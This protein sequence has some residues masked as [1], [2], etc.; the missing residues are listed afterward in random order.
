MLGWLAGL[1]AGAAHALSGPDHLAAVAPLA[2]D[3]PRG[4]WRLGLRWGAGHSC[5]VAA[6]GALALAARGSID[7]AGLSGY[8]ERLAG[9]ALVGV[10]VWGWR[11]ALP[12]FVHVH[13]HEHDGIR[14]RHVH[15]HGEGVREPQHGEHQHRHLAFGFG[16]LHGAGSATHLLG[17]LP[18]LLLPGRAQAL[19]YVASFALGT[20]AAMAGL[21]ALVGSLAGAAGGGARAYRWMLGAAASASVAVG[22]VW[23]LA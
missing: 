19:A 2:L 10:G 1:A 18:A 12:R 6:L 21:S 23:I 14:H 20:M 4:S 22:A 3:A 17:V 13:E 15:L 16:L 9:L 7:L 11:R 8:A 5:A